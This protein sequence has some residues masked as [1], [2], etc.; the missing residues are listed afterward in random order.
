MTVFWLNTP[1]FLLSDMIWDYLILPGNRFH[2]G[3]K[4][5]HWNE[6]DFVQRRGHSDTLQSLFHYIAWSGV[7]LVHSNP[8]KVLVSGVGCIYLRV[9][10]PT[11][12]QL[13]LDF[14]FLSF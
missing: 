12:F 2:G 9:A 10:H 14:Q 3:L 11:P 6:V 4:F 7:D 1:Y 8:F 5:V 13:L